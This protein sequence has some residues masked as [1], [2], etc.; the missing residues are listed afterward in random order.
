M[1]SL[2]N[3]PAVDTT[4]DSFSLAG[5]IAIVTGSG[6]EN[7]IGAATA[8][9]L[10][11]NG[12][13]VA[14]HYVSES[15]AQGAYEIAQSIRDEYGVDVA[16]VQGDISTPKGSRAIV[17][18][19][20]GKLGV[21]H[22]DILVNN[23]GY[24]VTRLLR[25][26]D[27]DLCQRTFATNVYGQLFMTQAVVDQGRMPPGG[28]IINIGSIA[29]KTHPAQVGLYAA[30][31]AAQDSLTTSWAGELGRTHG[32]TVNTVAP[33]PVVT[34]M[35]KDSPEVIDPMVLLQRGA[36]RR[37]M[38]GDI[39]DVVLLLASEGSRWVTGQ[40]IAADAGITGSR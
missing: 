2:M 9:A 22:I 21:N 40:F 28:R 4:A 1:P 3:R 6:R 39:A 34:D 31:K 26:T 37:G 38:P 12:A 18:G 17:A 25:E 11:R 16:C 10:A 27:F 8:R 19:A 32:I 5:K 29:S 14:I 36:E 23:A 7:G 24:G 20:L 30:S 13:S 35:A 15:S 33:G